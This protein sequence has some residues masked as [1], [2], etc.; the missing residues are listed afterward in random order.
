[1]SQALAGRKRPRFKR[2]GMKRAQKKKL[3]M[4]QLGVEAEKIIGIGGSDLSRIVVAA[5]S[6][7]PAPAASAPPDALQQELAAASLEVEDFELAE[8]HTLKEMRK[9]ETARDV[10]SLK[11][12]AA[13]ARLERRCKSK[14]P[15]Q[16]PSSSDIFETML[17]QHEKLSAA[18]IACLDTRV[19]A[20]AL[21]G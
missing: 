13:L 10:A 15:K 20:D 18:R 8:A 17:K 19:S 3:D 5:A 7:Q 6:S 1:M 11:N 12:D 14:D 4:P 2:V 21:S 9:A 16:K